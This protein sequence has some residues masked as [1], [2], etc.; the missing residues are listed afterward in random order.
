VEAGVVEVVDTTGVWMTHQQ[1]ELV[2][3]EVEWK[4]GRKE[5]GKQWRSEAMNVVG[6]LIRRNP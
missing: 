4:L 6:N 2:K 1:H 3:W 5:W